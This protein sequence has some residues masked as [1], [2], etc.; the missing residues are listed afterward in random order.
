MRLH[1]VKFGLACGI[2]WSLCLFVLTWISLGTG[3]AT[4]FLNIFAGIYPG[5]AITVIGSFLGLMY[6]FADGFIVCFVFG[7]LYNRLL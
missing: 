5:Y 1:A 2:L 7:W 3:Y 4:D 6:G